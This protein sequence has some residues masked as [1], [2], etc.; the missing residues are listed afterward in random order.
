MALKGTYTCEFKSDQALIVRSDPIVLTVAVGPMVQKLVGQYIQSKKG[1]D[2]WPPISR[3]AYIDLVLIKHGPSEEKV[4]TFAMEGDVDDFVKRE[5]NIEYKEAFARY[6]SGE[7]VLIEGRPGSRK[8]TLVQKISRDWARGEHILQGAKFVFLITLRMLSKR[9][10]I[11]FLD[12]LYLFYH[13]EKLAHSVSEHIDESDGKGVCFIIDG[14]DEYTS[15]D[16]DESIIF[17]IIH[18]EYLYQSIVIV[19][20]RPVAAGELRHLADTSVEVLG[21]LKKIVEF[22]ENYPFTSRHASQ[23]LNLYLTKHV[24]ILHMCYL[25]VHTAMVCFLYDIVKDN[26]LNTETEVYKHF[27]MLSVLRALKRTSKLT[28]LAS[29]QDLPADQNEFFPENM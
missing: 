5:E 22:V 4:D 20:S 29:I 25:P 21:F 24:N 13:N 3:K 10:Y 1:G 27:T 7:S 9:A 11:K 15:E 18:K 2:S 19:A 28:K 16:K 12:I 26:L 14:L 8:T 6:K 23:K 17:K